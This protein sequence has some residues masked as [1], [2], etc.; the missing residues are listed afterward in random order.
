MGYYVT[1]PGGVVE[2]PP[3]GKK[4]FLSL[5]QDQSIGDHYSVAHGVPEIVDLMSKIAEQSLAKRKADAKLAVEEE[6]KKPKH[7]SAA[8][9]IVVETYWERPEA[10]K[11][12]L[13]DSTDERDII[14]VLEEWI[15]RLQQANKTIDGWKDVVDK[16]DVDNLC[17][18]FDVF[19]IRQRCSILCL[20][21]IYALDEEMNSARWIEDSCAQ[22]ILDSSKMGIEAATTAQAV[23]GWNILLRAN[24]EHFPLP[25][26]RTHKQNNPLPDLLKYFQEEITLPWLEYCIENLADLTV[27]LAWNELIT[28]II[29]EVNAQKQQEDLDRV[30][31]GGNSG[32]NDE[33]DGRN[34]DNTRVQDCLLQDYLDYP[35]SISMAWRWLR[36]LGFS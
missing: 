27:E 35:I 12:F 23:S 20:V 25:N 33:E 30:N 28:K 18:Y 13:G 3:D 16:H 15:E 1:A 19:I 29:P 14:K 9:K 31:D 2:C 11:L 32:G 26:P 7:G 24:R 6:A 21:Y 10:K 17:S 5:L 4:S 36:C 8:A 22:A 34:E